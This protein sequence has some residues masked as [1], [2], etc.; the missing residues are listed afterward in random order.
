MSWTRVYSNDAHGS[1]RNGYTNSDLTAL[2]DHLTAVRNIR[3]WLNVDE[4]LVDPTDRLRVVSPTSRVFVY[5]GNVYA[6]VVQAVMNVKGNTSLTWNTNFPESVALFGTDGKERHRLSGGATVLNQMPMDWYVDL[7]V[8]SSDGWT[9]I[10]RRDINGNT[11]GSV[12]TLISVLQT[13]APIR[14][15]MDGLGVTATVFPTERAW[16]QGSNVYVVLPLVLASV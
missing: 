7:P 1:P 16:V 15:G 6:E 8:G 3:V 2:I 11:A 14:L 12:S 4:M 13:G 5:S 9:Q 10:Y